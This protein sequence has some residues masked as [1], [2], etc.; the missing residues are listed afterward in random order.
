MTLPRFI[1][2]TLLGATMLFASNTSYKSGETLIVSE[3]DS[4]PG[5]LFYG[6][7][8][9]EIEGNSAGDIIVGSQKTFISGQVNDDVYAWSEGIRVE[10]AVGDLLLGFAKEITIKGTV[11]G[12]VIAYGGTVHILKGAQILGDLY[13]GT[14]YLFIDQAHISG[15]VK[16]GA[17]KI[18]LNGTFEKDI[19]LS[20]KEVQFGE[21]FSVVGAVH[22]TLSEEPEQPIEN[23]PANLEIEIEPIKHFFTSLMFFWFFLSALVIGFILMTLV[24]GLFLNLVA[25][26]RTKL[27]AVAGSGALFLIVT[28]VVAIFAILFL[29]LTFILTA[30]FLI[31]I[32]LSKIFTA[33]I[34]GEYFIQKL[35]P[36]KQM[37]RYLQFFFG[38]LVLTLL[39]K[40]P[41]LGFFVGLIS[42]LIGSGA[43]VYYLLTIRKNGT[44][45]TV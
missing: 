6:G 15:K 12:D 17:K 20:A 45:K 22:L 1:L 3:N 36:G 7:R 8:Y 25:L 27:A 10:G 19:D 44:A 31:L 28:P 2:F 40:I 34:A 23:A 21:N 26:T 41:F 29:P 38:L 9:L 43:F 32:Y 37:N 24:P 42:V 39:I 16:G 35:M 11:H 5:D 30:L 18:H 14:G 4:L 33:Y 13:V